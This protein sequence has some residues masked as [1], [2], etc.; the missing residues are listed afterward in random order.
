MA[1]VRANVKSYADTQL[2]NLKA[3]TSGMTA[4]MAEDPSTLADA[5]AKEE[6]MDFKHQETDLGGADAPTK[7]TTK[8]KVSSDD[9]DSDSDMV[10]SSRPAR[11]ADPPSPDDLEAYNEIANVISNLRDEMDHNGSMIYTSKNPW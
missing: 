4:A 10:V 2:T 5:L 7:A 1:A 6:A 8:A 3:L 9:E 11:A